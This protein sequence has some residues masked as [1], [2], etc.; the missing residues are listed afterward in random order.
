MTTLLDDVKDL[1]ASKWAASLDAHHDAIGRPTS[2]TGDMADWKMGFM[3]GDGAIMAM[4][5][6]RQH[7]LAHVSPWGLIDRK[8]V[9]QQL[10]QIALAEASIFEGRCLK[11]ICHQGLSSYYLSNHGE[12]QCAYSKQRLKNL[13][14]TGMCACPAASIPP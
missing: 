8:D 12:P 2:A 14:A 4:T 6:S 5:N 10:R 7:T 11:R 1:P 13:E 3:V 9:A